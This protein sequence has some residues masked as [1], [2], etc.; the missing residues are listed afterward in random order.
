M[1]GH[2]VDLRFRPL[3]A[4][5]QLSDP[6]RPGNRPSREKRKGM[7]VMLETIQESELFR[8]VTPRVLTEIANGSE[9]MTYPKGTILFSAG[10]T[11]QDIYELVDGSIDLM[12]PEKELV[13][14]TVSRG[15]QMFGWSALVEPY[16]R[17]ATAKCT[18]DTKVLRM[19]RG[20]IERT[21]ERHPHEGLAILKNLMGI[22]AH[23]LRQAYAYIQYCA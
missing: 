1:Q 6:M 22:I 12:A 21:I 19:S 16:E 13:H 17:T 3:G 7:L 23:R 15:G 9:E 14:L 20:S 10:E 18:T 4:L 8:G 5:N 2:K 11:A